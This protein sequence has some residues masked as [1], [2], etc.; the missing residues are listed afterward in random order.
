MKKNT[1]IFDMDGVIID[2]EP[3]WREAQ[4]KVLA[5]QNVTITTQDCILNTMGK[6][7]DDVAII[8]CQLHQLTIAPKEIEIQIIDLVVQLIGI[9]GKSKEGLYQLLDYLTQT[10]YTIALATSSSIP[11]INAVFDKLSIATY[12]KVVASADNELY[13]KPHPAVYL[14]V[15]KELQVTASDCFVLED[16]VTGM[17]AGKAAVMTTMVIPENK[18]DPRFTLADEIFES[19]IEV[20][21]YLKEYN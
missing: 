20:I 14:K 6:R 1:F 9:R 17:I 4:I 13:G 7:I 12:F 10:N 11:I 19:M 15:A 2:S 5:K 3:I 16:S 8:W 18:D 21:D